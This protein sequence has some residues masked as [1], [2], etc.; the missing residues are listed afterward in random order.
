MERWAHQKRPRARSAPCHTYRDGW[1][2][3][4]SSGLVAGAGS[5][6]RRVDRERCSR[7]SSRPRLLSSVDTPSMP[8]R[9][10]L[11]ALGGPVG[12]RG[13]RIPGE[14]RQLQVR[15]GVLFHASC[16]DCPRNPAPILQDIPETLRR[17][18]QIVRNR[19]DGWAVL[20]PGEQVREGGAR[21]TRRTR[22][23]IGA[24]FRGQSAQL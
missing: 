4:G 10:P 21:P 15:K 2:K 22:C 23:R 16:A 5:R 9:G 24:G 11:V 18:A 7:G 14:V 1:R 8:Q 12:R 6:H 17:S 20:V 13:C 19:E 3:C